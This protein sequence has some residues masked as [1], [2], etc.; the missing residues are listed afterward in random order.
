LVDPAIVITVQVAARVTIALPIDAG[1]GRVLIRILITGPR[2]LA[3]RQAAVVLLG[4]SGRTVAVIPTII[5]VPPAALAITIIPIVTVI[6]A[7][8][9]IAIVAGVSTIAAVARILVAP[10]IISPVPVPSSSLRDAT[11]Y[12]AKALLQIVSFGAT[13]A[14][15]AIFLLTF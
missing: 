6:S 2:R 4:Q 14:V 13:D 3:R 1:H 8:G 5:L 10:V 7:V 12:P 9:F 11:I 15:P